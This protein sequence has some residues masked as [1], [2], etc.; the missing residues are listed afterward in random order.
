[1]FKNWRKKWFKTLLKHAKPHFFLTPEKAR[2]A[3]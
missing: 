3:A 1:M 2:I